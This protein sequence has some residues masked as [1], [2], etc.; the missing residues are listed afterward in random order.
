M[1][2]YIQH[3]QDRITANRIYYKYLGDEEMMVESERLG[4]S[5]FWV[6]PFFPELIAVDKRPARD[7]GDL[8]DANRRSANIER[9]IA[10]NRSLGK[11]FCVNQV[12]AA[13]PLTGTGD[14]L[15]NPGAPGFVRQTDAT[16]GYR[17]RRLERRIT[18]DPRTHM[19]AAIFEMETELMS[20]IMGASPHDLGRI[21]GALLESFVSSQ[22]TIEAH[23]QEITG[24]V[25]TVLCERPRTGLVGIRL[26][27]PKK[28]PISLARFIDPGREDATELFNR[29]VNIQYADGSSVF[30]VD[31]PQEKAV[32][33]LLESAREGALYA[34]P[35]ETAAL[36][37][38]RT[39]GLLAVGRR[40]IA[41]ETSV[42]NK[43]EVVDALVVALSVDCNKI[44]AALKILEDD[45][46]FPSLPIQEKLD[47][48]RSLKLKRAV[49][50][51]LTRS[52]P[53]VEEH[54][55]ECVRRSGGNV[56]ASEDLFAETLS[57]KFLGLNFTPEDARF[58]MY[59]VLNPDRHDE[60]RRRGYL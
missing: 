24:E 37:S 31:D 49:E 2:E 46:E 42:E 10:L 59:A 55:R 8:E 33:L 58:F 47:R 17:L 35:E 38:E 14:E 45:A 44:D 39:D 29:L 7:H 1:E 9:T 34:R 5:S 20:E 56:I 21:R 52:I 22:K 4:R 11:V 26:N 18:D 3:R 32:L 16:G 23:I 51:T 53:E 30:N 50:S 27:L 41:R 19:M 13:N 60:Y 54:A 6:R 57:K 48:L 12:A 43:S 36:I 25:E 15:F 40:L 28:I